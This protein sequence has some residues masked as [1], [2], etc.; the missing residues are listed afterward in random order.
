MAPRNKDTKDMICRNYL[1]R[2]LCDAT[3]KKTFFNRE[4]FEKSL[5]LKKRLFPIEFRITKPRFKPTPY[6]KPVT[7]SQ[8]RR[9][10]TPNSANKENQT[11]ST[12]NEKVN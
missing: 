10:T 5:P 9:S 1:Y 3:K 8:K 12:D 11:V 2:R 7:R 4:T 6:E